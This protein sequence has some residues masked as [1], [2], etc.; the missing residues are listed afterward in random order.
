MFRI[1]HKHDIPQRCAYDK[2]NRKLRGFGFVDD[3]T[4]S[5]FCDEICA[6]KESNERAPKPLKIQ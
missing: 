1:K 3:N 6:M 2:C 5:I 4:G